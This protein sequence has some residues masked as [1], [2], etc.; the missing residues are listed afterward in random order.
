MVS[1]AYWKEI[2]YVEVAQTVKLCGFKDLPGKRNDG[3]TKWRQ[4]E[5]KWDESSFSEPEGLG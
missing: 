5:E 2:N 3:S 1:T 4:A